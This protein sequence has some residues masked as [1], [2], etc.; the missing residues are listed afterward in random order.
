M[1]FHDEIDDAADANQNNSTYRN[2]FVTCPIVG[3]QQPTMQ[4]AELMNGVIS[5]SELLPTWLSDRS[6]LADGDGTVPQVSAIPVQM[7]DIEAL[8][9]VDHIA[10]KH[11][12]L[13]NQP[14]VLLNLLKGIQSAQTASLEDVRGSLKTVARGKRSGLKGIGLSLDDLYV[15]KEPITM[16]AKIS[17]DA[18][19][20][21]LT[22]EITCVSHDRPAITCNFTAENGN[23]SVTTD[24]LEAGLYKVKVQTDNTS[25]DAPNPV[26]A[27]FEI[28]DLN[29][30]V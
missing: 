29:K 24:A 5:T 20:N 18:S 12:A 19:F 4:S 26:R 16:R 10:E 25:A 1:N 15:V 17:G 3:V 23:W 21:S 11:G 9:L 27:L 28:V 6:H 13:Q 8:S 7:G 22:A 2:T 30:G 14:D